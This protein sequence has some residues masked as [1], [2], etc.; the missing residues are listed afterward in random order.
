MAASGTDLIHHLDFLN[1]AE[2]YRRGFIK[3]LN[4]EYTYGDFK[5]DGS[6]LSCSDFFK[7]INDFNYIELS[8]QKNVFKYFTDILFLTLWTI[9][10]LLIIRNKTKNI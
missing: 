4:H 10:L 8:I 1:K 6:N 2:I 3:A 9:I 5:I 7:S